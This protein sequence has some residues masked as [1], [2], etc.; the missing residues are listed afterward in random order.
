MSNKINQISSSKNYGDTTLKDLVDQPYRYGFKTDI[1]TE[2]FPRGL[3]ET[4]VTL[5]S[6]KRSEPPFL[7]EFRL[8]A[9]KAWTG[10]SSPEWA[11]VN[12]A[13]IDYQN[14]VYYSAPKLKK[15]TV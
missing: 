14:I 11:C 13:D 6:Q 10:M 4:I 3:D 9:Y 2:D 1:E 7:L 12:H 5:I 15:K 8:R